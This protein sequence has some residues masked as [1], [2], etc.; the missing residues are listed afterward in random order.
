MD[1]VK[2]KIL[3]RHIEARVL[4]PVPFTQ[5]ELEGIFDAMDEYCGKPKQTKEQREERFAERVHLLSTGYDER[6]VAKFIDY[7][8]ESNP[9][10]KLRFELQKTFEIERRLKRWFNNKKGVTTKSVPKNPNEYGTW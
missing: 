6:E 10:G 4:H 2:F 8:T 1:E 5:E 3:M 9:R 7:W